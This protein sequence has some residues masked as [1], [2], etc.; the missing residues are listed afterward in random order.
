MKNLIM[1][2]FL[3]CVVLLLTRDKTAVFI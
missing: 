3:F 2:R 1:L